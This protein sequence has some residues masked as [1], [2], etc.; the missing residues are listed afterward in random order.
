MAL[1][2]NTGYPGQSASIANF[3]SAPLTSDASAA[4]DTY[5]DCGFQPR[6]IKLVNITDLSTQEFCD[7]MPSGN[8]LNE[9]AAGTKTLVAAGMVVDNNGVT[10]KAAIIPASKSFYMLAFA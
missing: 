8:C 10:L 5:I 6:Y 7:G 4:A 9:V 3:F 1:T 2:I